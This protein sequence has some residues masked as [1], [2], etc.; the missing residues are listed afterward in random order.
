M[1]KIY[2]YLV[3]LVIFLLIDLTWLGV[4]ARS[5]Y[6]EQL[7][8]L[9]RTNP[10]WTAAFLFYALYV[11]GVL[12]LVVYP[13]VDQGAGKIFLLGAFFGLVAYATFDLTNLAILR[14]W[15]LKMA[16][17]DLLWGAFLTGLVAY[18]GQ[19]VIG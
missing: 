1:E 17:V 18:L 7:G 2:H 6:R 5:F 4:V 3:T 13:N 9:M 10:N 12:V 19:R 8:S 14:D 11:L 16:L 15:P